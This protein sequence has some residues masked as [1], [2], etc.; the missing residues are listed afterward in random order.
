VSSAAGPGIAGAILA[1]AKWPWLFAVNLPIG[2]LVLAFGGALAHTH[3]APRRLN[4]LTVA[5][6]ALMFLLFFNGADRAA[7][8]PL[9]G[10]VLIAGAVLCLIVIVR[11]E[12][13]KD[14]PLIPV[15]LFVAPAFRI[16]VAASVCCFTGQMLSFVALPFYLQHDLGLN[17]M[18]TGLYMTPWPIAVAIVAPLSGRL[19]GHVRTAWL[20]GVGGALLALGLIVIVAFPQAGAL[21]FLIGGVIAGAGFGLFQTPNNRILLLSAPKARSGAAGAMQGTARLSGQTFGSILM[22][23]IFGIAPLTAAP[24]LAILIAAAFTALA[25]AVSLTRARYEGGAAG[26]PE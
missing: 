6:N 9:T 17:P 11:L 24:R 8:A 10:A 19:S 16:A 13:G 21:G 7:R 20:C 2:A 14:A 26:G 15:D 4:L 23:V 1:V 25:A 3:G 22:A 12:R 5:L 18:Q